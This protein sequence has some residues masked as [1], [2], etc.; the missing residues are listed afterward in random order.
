MKLTP[1]VSLLALVVWVAPA[2]LEAQTV[3]DVRAH[4]ALRATQIGAL[5]PLPTPSML[6]RT[7]NGVQLGV[8]YGFLDERGFASH[9]LALSVVAEAGF[10]NSV[11]LTAGARDED[12]TGCTPAMLFGI[13]GDT[14]IFDVGEVMGGG[15]QLSVA[16]GGDVA[17]AQLKPGDDYA[18]A[19]GVN[20]PITLALRDQAATGLRV[21]PF[22]IPTFGIGQTSAPCPGDCERSGT[23]FVLGAGVA[24]WSPASSLS[25]SLGLSRV[26]ADG[27]RTVYGVNVVIGGR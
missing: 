6:Y 18:V 5:T 10:G 13:G 24:A 22:F 3:G 2:H 9:A 7:L 25:A 19:I 8:R 12:C 11:T 20:A 14:R 23:R 27:A 26:L 15:T 1:S 21:A 17:Y 16:V 4:T